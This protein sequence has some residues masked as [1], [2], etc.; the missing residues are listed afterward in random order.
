MAL[1]EALCAATM[2][3]GMA[4][5]APWPDVVPALNRLKEH[6][7][8]VRHPGRARLRDRER[9]DHPDLPAQRRSSSRG[10]AGLSCASIA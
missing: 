2:G 8:L 7:D 3:V 1:D 6:F 4:V 10:S 9:H 5:T